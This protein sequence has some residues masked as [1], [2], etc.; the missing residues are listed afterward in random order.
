[1][2]NF[3]SSYPVLAAIALFVA[4]FLLMIA[5]VVIPLELAGLHPDLFQWARAVPNIALP[6]FTPLAFFSIMFYIESVLCAV[7]LKTKSPFRNLLLSKVLRERR[8]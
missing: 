5:V 6:L 1:M 8:E 7:G 2:R 4:V 3:V